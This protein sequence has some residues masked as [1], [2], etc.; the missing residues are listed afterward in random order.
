M[1]LL[2]HIVSRNLAPEVAATQSLAYILR[3]SP[4]LAASL[5]DLLWPSV[6]FKLGHVKSKLRFGDARPDLTIFDSDGR[7]RI[8]VVNKFWA[9]LTDAQPVQYL[10]ALPDDLPS[11]LVFI[12]PEQRIPTV[13]NELKRRS[14]GAYEFGNESSA[15]RVTRLQMGTRTMC[16][17]SWRHVL[18]MLERTSTSD[19]V[20]RDVLQLEGLARSRESHG[21]PPLRGEE[22]SDVGI[23]RRMIDYCNLVEDII[24]ELRTRRVAQIGRWR[25]T[26]TWYDTGG[27]FKAFGRF[28]FWLG[29]SLVP[30]K[31]AGNTPLWLSVTPNL[32]N[33]YHRL[34]RFFDDVQELRGQKRFRKKVA[35]YLPIRLRTGAER[36]GVIRDAADQVQRI[37]EKIEGIIGAEGEPAEVP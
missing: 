8:F 36:D 32:G 18:R 17:T 34:E 13:W 27:Y 28:D 37:V 1:S 22:L 7:H 23:P 16:A 3:S 31:N 26:H 4:D 29:V 24:R 2:A 11:G 10:H 19:A 6:G 15:G 21:F 5:A 14:D 20:R 33:H 30:W 25:A 12:L 35:K 9:G